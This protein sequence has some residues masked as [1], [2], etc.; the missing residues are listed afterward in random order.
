VT[1]DRPLLNRGAANVTECHSF[2]KCSPGVMGENEASPL[3]PV[4]TIDPPVSESRGGECHRM[5][6]F[7]QMFPLV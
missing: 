7:Q 5:S 2:S 3:R 4:L 1:I 6:Q